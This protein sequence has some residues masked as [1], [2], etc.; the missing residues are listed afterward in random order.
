MTVTQSTGTVVTRYALLNL[1]IF[2][3]AN[4]RPVILVFNTALT[5]LTTPHVQHAT[6]SP[7][8]TH[9]FWPVRPIAP[10]Y[11]TVQHATSL[12]LLEMIL[13]NA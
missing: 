12:L 4:L 5:A 13:L 2:V 9:Q 1:P 11:I 7:N 6:H 8:G 3:K 10:L